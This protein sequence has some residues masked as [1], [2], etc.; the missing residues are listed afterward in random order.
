MFIS[1]L[2][3]TVAAPFGNANNKQQDSD[4]SPVACFGVMQFYLLFMD[5]PLDLAEFAL[6]L[7]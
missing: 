5:T 1:P 4:L 2:F 7:L 6:V 3:F